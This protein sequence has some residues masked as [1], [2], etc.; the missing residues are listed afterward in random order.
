M[1]TLSFLFLGVLGFFVSADSARAQLE[2]RLSIKVILDA[3][4]DRP[5]GGNLSTDAGINGAVADANTLLTSFGRG[6]TFRVTEIRDLSGQTGLLNLDCKDASDAIE[7]GV[8]SNPASYIWRTNAL[9]V[10]INKGDDNASCAFNGLLVMKYTS[11]GGTFVHEGAHHL[12]LCHT[13]G[14]GCKDCTDCPAIVTDGISDTLPDRECWRVD[15]ISIYAYF[16]FFTNLTAT[17]KAAVSNTFNNV[18]SYHKN[19]TNDYYTGTHDVLTAG[20][21]DHLADYA[22]TNRASIMNGKTLFVDYTNT[23]CVPLGFSQ[24][25]GIIGGPYPSVGQ[26]ITAATG[27]DIVLIRRGHYNEPMTITKPITLRATRGDAFLG[28]P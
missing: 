22:R 6:Y 21:W 16:T 8:Q 3:N 27:G 15:D 2:V 25:N 14:C 23:I 11:S 19:I 26:G 18:M 10:Y 12:G 13:Q 4:G 7:A 1:R 17:Q 24:C 28:S 9:N 5:T 20:Q